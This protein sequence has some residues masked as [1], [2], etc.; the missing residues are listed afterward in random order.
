MEVLHLLFAC[1][2]CESYCRQFRS[3]LLRSWDICQALINSLSFLILCPRGL[4]LIQTITD[5]LKLWS[6]AGH[7]SQSGLSVAQSCVLHPWSTVVWR[8][9]R[10]DVWYLCLV[11]CCSHMFRRGGGGGSRFASH[12]AHQS[13]LMVQLQACRQN[14]DSYV[15]C[16]CL[17][18]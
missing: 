5:W 8:C 13:C 3:V 4:I 14:E 12:H 7:N 1:M 17:R 6:S 9:R 15:V 2:P 11:A 10:S 16:E 18:P